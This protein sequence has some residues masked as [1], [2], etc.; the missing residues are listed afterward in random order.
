MKK[1]NIFNSQYIPDKDKYDEFV[2]EANEVR[3][4]YDTLS[5]KFTAHKKEDLARKI[6]H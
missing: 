4:H 2:S 1:Q 5:S 3:E 6:H